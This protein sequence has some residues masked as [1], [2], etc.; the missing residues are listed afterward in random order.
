MR[1]SASPAAIDMRSTARVGGGDSFGLD[2]EFR[3]LVIP[4]FRLLHDH[5]WRVEVTGGKHVPAEGLIRFRAG[6]AGP[7]MQA[8][9]GAARVRRRLQSMVTRLK[10][11][12]RSVFFG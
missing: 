6:D 12:L 1:A 9:D 2:A 5:Y 8:H 3:E 11:R 10:N 4:A 7:Y